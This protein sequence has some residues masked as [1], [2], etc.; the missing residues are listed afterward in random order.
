MS[1]CWIQWK[2][3]LNRRSTPHSSTAHAGADGGMVLADRV[4]IRISRITRSAIMHSV[5]SEVVGF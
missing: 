2:K 1:T 3:L 4:R 5:W